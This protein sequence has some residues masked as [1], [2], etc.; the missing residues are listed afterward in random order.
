LTNPEKILENEITVF[1]DKVRIDVQTSTPGI[2]FSES[3]TKKEVMT[4]K[5]QQFY[6]LAKDDLIASKKAAG[7]NIDLEDV[8]MLGA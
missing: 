6:V 3:W 1:K 4:F 8:R 5:G 2:T 7:R